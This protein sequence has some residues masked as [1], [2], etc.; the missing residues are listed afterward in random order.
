M[1]IAMDD[2]IGA[3]EAPKKK[4]AGTKKTAAKKTAGRT[5]KDG[6]KK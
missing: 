4:P 5:A 3:I 6:D 1:A 2:R